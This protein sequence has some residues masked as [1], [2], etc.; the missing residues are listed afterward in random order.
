MLT[1]KMIVP[2]VVALVVGAGSWT[3]AVAHSFTQDFCCCD[4]F[5]ECLEVGTWTFVDCIPPGREDHSDPR[6][7]EGH[8]QDSCDCFC[9]CGVDP[10]CIPEVPDG[11]AAEVPNGLDDDCDG[12]IDDEQCD[13]TDNDGDGMVDEDFNSCLM[14]IL[15]VPMGDWATFSSQDVF[16]AL[17]LEQFVT[18]KTEFGIDDAIGGCPDNF[19]ISFMSIDTGSIP[20]TSCTVGCGVNEVI[21]S[22]Q[23]MLGGSVND[24]DVIVA[25]TRPASLIPLFGGICGNIEGCSDGA[26]AL[27]FEPDE[28]SLLAHEL[29]HFLGLTDEYNYDLNGPPNSLGADLGCDSDPGSIGTS[30]CALCSGSDVCCAGNDNRS[31]IECGA[32]AICLDPDC[33]HCPEAFDLSCAGRCIMSYA[34]ACGG[35]GYCQRCFD[36]ATAPP[37]VRAVGNEDGQVPMDCAF[38]HLGAE[39]NAGASVALTEEGEMSVVHFAIGTGRLGLGKRSTSGRY[40]IEIRD[41]AGTLLNSSSFD[42]SFEYRD[43]KF[44]DVDY[45]SINYDQVVR[46]FRLR[47]GPEVDEDDVLRIIALKDGVVTWQSTANGLPPLADAGSNRT[48]EC[49]QPESAT[50]ALDG[51]GSSDPDG[52][53]LAYRWSAPGI[54]FDDASSPTPSAVFPLGTTTVT[55]VVNDGIEDSPADTMDVTVV[56]TTAPVIEVLGLDPPELWPPNHRMV[57]VTAT[58]TASDVCDPNPLTIVLTSVTSDEP[59]NAPGGGDGNTTNDIQGAELGLPDFSFELRAERAGSGDGRI[60]TAI[61]TATDIS[62]NAASD[63]GFVLVPHDQGG[64]TDPIAARLEQSASGTLLWW[65]AAPGAESYDVIRGVLN[66]VHDAGPVIDLGPVTC[67]ENDSLDETTAGMEDAAVPA[68]GGVFFYLVQYFDGMS[69]SYGAESAGKPL[70]PGPGGCE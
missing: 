52:D 5:G 65:S 27:W 21:T 7:Q 12:F 70:A 10:T 18:F 31:G 43:P 34:D 28:P 19:S 25:M 15:F 40:G 11:A 49:N 32:F 58:V 68:P 26:S 33:F 54:V 17:A 47:V 30:C 23:G 35:R 69:S 66:N 13:N 14:K 64:G 38:A 45:S 36:H 61:Y 22:V 63:A 3:S 59:D 67:I 48:A 46:S 55:L 44:R 42:L 39:R 29:G 60:Y 50:V 51:T 9:A 20:E 57:A 37:D 6:C 24:F 16:E 2:Y 41:L 53:S 62:G 56:D 1:R 8:R 4:L